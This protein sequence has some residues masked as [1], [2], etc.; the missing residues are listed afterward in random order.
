MV[1]HECL[2][3]FDRAPHAF[4]PPSPST[5]M[6]SLPVATPA[7]GESNARMQQ[8]KAHQRHDAP[9][10]RRAH[11][12]ANESHPGRTSE[13]FGR[14]VSVDLRTKSRANARKKKI[15][16]RSHTHPPDK[17]HKHEKRKRPQTRIRGCATFL[18]TARALFGHSLARGQ[19]SET[20]SATT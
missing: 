14:Q 20:F 4:A 16:K 15:R 1:A 9:T 19:L 7:D 18:N 13:G 6:A 12:D 17:I 2:Q 10:K 8:H 5:A 3:D 11:V